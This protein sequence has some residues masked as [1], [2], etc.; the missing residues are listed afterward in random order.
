MSKA[1][2]SHQIIIE[3][4]TLLSVIA[5]LCKEDVK[6]LF[7]EVSQFPAINACMIGKMQELLANTFQDSKTISDSLKLPRR[8]S[9]LSTLPSIS[10]QIKARQ[11]S[12]EDGMSSERI[13]KK[14]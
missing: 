9:R 6:T 11:R 12:N 13:E 3:L 7:V 5:T 1:P 10:T 14:R 4:P 2:N 8:R